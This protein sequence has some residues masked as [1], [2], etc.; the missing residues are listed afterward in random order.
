MPVILATWKLISVGLWLE[1]V[2]DKYVHNIPSYPIARQ[3]CACH[4]SYC[5]KP[6]IRGLR[7]RPAWTNKQDP[8]PKITRAKR[9]AG[10]AQA[11]EHLLSSAKSN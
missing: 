2:L 1:A 8:I 3:W 4:L 10:V 11:V 5:R 6:N 7:S 9:A